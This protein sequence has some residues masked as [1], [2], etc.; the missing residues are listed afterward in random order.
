MKI[1]ALYEIYKSHSNISTDTRR[2]SEN[3]L[4]FALKGDNF[5]GNDFAEKAINEGCAYA[6]IDQ[7]QYTAIDQ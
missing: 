3:C 4:F 7:K 1:E 5:N 2:I 6:I